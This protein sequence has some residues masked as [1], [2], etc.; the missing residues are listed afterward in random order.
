[1]ATSVTA[2]R[3]REAKLVAALDLPL[4]DLRGLAGTVFRQPEQELEAAYFDTSDDR[5][6]QHRLTLR[7]R[8]GEGPSAG[9]WTLKVPE[10]DRRTTVD[11]TELTW[12][13]S[14]DHV[15][16]GARRIVA[17]VV[18]EADL[19]QVVELHT[20]R[21]PLELRDDAGRTWAV[22]DDDTVTVHGGPRD[23]L[24]FR[25]VEVEL[26]EPGATTPDSGGDPLPKVLAALEKAGAR[27]HDDPK[28]AIA[29]GRSSDGGRPPA[30]LDR[31]SRLVDVVAR[32]LGSGLDRLLDHD[33][34]LRID[35]AHPHERDVHQARVATRRLRADLKTFEPVLDEVWVRRTRDELRWLGTVLGAVRDLDVLTSTLAVPAK[36]APIDAA[37][38]RELLGRLDEQRR[39]AVRELAETL[40]DPR[41]LRLVGRLHAA[42]GSP[43]FRSG[44]G[45]KKGRRRRTDPDAPARTVLP[46]LVRPAWRRLRRRV[47]RGGHHPSNR[48][49][50]RIRIAAKQLRYAS[51]VAQPVIGAPAR[52]TAKAASALQTVLGDHHDAVAAEEWLWNEALRASPWGS[53]SA[54]QLHAE[55]RRRQR[56][57]GRRWRKDWGRIERRRLR[58]WLH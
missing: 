51:E 28:V 50:H 25:E 8:L 14:R 57:L 48:Q 27:R 12:P 21:R 33:V 56:R 23:G 26:S 3:E 6:W 46:E 22:L 53:F 34:R 31:H 44:R 17:A 43:P 10:R 58:R 32:S 9:T 40:E 37:G 52:H 18:R 24:R 1:M 42:A 15:P 11:R 2:H 54:G 7:H 41:C 16:D 35:P 29:L 30:G 4:P 13:G 36:G 38:R 49:L 19:S 47:R 55:L 39:V 45:P 20:V 5:L